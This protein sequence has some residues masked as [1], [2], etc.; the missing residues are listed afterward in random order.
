[1]QFLLVQN[2]HQTLD[3]TLIGSSANGIGIQVRCHVLTVYIWIFELGQ[4]LQSYFGLYRQFTITEAAEECDV[5]LQ[6]IS[7]FFY[8]GWLTEFF[9]KHQDMLRSG[10]FCV[11]LLFNSHL[12][13]NVAFYLE[14]S[15]TQLSKKNAEIFWLKLC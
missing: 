9:P 15:L 6:G 12:G 8:R 4:S 13:S 10:L 1:M 7:W 5:G 3:W 11:T 2:R 14:I